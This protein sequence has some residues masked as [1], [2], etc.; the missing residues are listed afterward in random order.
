MDDFARQLFD[1]AWNG[2]LT[3]IRS[4]VASGQA[5]P[6]RA[7]DSALEAAAYNA[8]PEALDL[9]LSLGADA[10]TVHAPTGETVLH[11][12]ITKTSDAAER[13]RI[14]RSLVDGGADVNA[15]TIPGVETRCFMRDIRTCGET[16]LRRAAAYGDM[17][18]IS[19]L[20]EAGADKSA[21][22]SHGESPLT[23]ASWHLRQ[24]EVIIMLLFNEFEGTLA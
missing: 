16:P 12:V 13:T 14:V 20:V 9:L 15:R 6:D 19:I 21:R 22:D 3:N 5:L 24:R 8:K 17:E 18:M 2:D 23:R 1:A 11:Q 10:N 4:V 7:L